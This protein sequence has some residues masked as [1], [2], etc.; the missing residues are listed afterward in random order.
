[1]ETNPKKDPR[2]YT[3]RELPALCASME[4]CESCPIDPL[5]G[6]CH[7]GP[8]P[9]EWELDDPS[10]DVDPDELR[11]AVQ[12][13]VDDIAPGLTEAIKSITGAIKAVAE[14]IRDNC[15][16]EDTDDAADEDTRTVTLYGGET[17]TIKVG[18]ADA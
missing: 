4:D 8:I 18:D 7:G 9:A 3:L 14:Y 1:M 13:F 16:S 17:L 11:E 15:A 10:L 5:R 6:P 12:K 2:D